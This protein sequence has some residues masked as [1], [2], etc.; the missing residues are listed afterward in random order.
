MSEK[1]K[2]L[3]VSKISSV[4]PECMVIIIHTKFTEPIKFCLVL[5]TFYNNLF[6]F[7]IQFPNK[8]IFCWVITYNVLHPFY[9]YSF[10]WYFANII[11]FAIVSV[12]GKQF[13]AVIYHHPFNPGVHSILRSFTIQL[14]CRER[15]RMR[16][17]SIQDCTIFNVGTQCGKKRPSALFHHL[18]QWAYTIQA[19]TFSQ[20]TT[21]SS[22]SPSVSVSA[23]FL[24]CHV[25]LM[26]LAVS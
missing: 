11:H 12:I 18:G 14:N 13:V 25:N 19:N 10:H 15:T 21:S 7:Y 26:P 24:R 4:H 1:N 8:I 20:N 17:S 16:L 3:H 23:I 2:F 22:S 6:A 9:T 5:L